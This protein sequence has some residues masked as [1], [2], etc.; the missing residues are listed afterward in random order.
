MRTLA[1]IASVTA[2]I[3][4]IHRICIEALATAHGMSVS[5]IHAVLHDDLG[6]EKK[7]A[8][9][10]AKLL[11]E[12]QK[13]QRV[14]VCSEFIKAVHRH[15]LTMLDSIGTMDETMVCYHMPQS[16]KQSQQWIEK[17]QPGSIKAK[18]QASR[19]KQMLLA[20]SKNINKIK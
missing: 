9:W 8:R 19:T 10:V 5:T 20:C 6:L 17:G 3:E 1:L 15:S 18:V 4:E 7:S 13:Q 12:E 11:N 14:E 2:A 16:K